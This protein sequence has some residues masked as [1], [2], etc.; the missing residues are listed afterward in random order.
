MHVEIVSTRATVAH[1]GRAQQRELLPRPAAAAL[2]VVLRLVRVPGRVVSALRLRGV[3]RLQR[4]RCPG[5]LFWKIHQPPSIVRYKT[6][7]M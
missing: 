3:G 6:L 2:L 7:G 1:G 4:S 5:F